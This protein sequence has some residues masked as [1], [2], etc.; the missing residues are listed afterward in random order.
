M[1]E[2]ALLTRNYPF[3]RKIDLSVEQRRTKFRKRK[4]RSFARSCEDLGRVGMLSLLLNSN[5]LTIV[6]VKIYLPVKS[7]LLPDMD[8]VLGQ[9]D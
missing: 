4:S 6:T 3:G 2:F 8:S 5:L 1:K 7:L 9:Y